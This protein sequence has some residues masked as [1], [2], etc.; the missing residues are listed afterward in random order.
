MKLQL[1]FSLPNVRLILLL[2]NLYPFLK[3]FE[4]KHILV[5]V[6]FPIRLVC[7][8]PINRLVT[9]HQN[10]NHDQHQLINLRSN[11]EFQ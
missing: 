3:D 1:S 6:L 5:Q 9:V 10:L 8:I 4:V 7:Q 11:L 2:D